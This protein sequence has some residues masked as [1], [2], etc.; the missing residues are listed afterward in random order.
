MGF[1]TKDAFNIAIELVGGSVMLIQTFCKSHHIGCVPMMNCFGTA[2]VCMK[3]L[4]CLH[5][6]LTCSSRLT[7][8]CAL[9]SSSSSV[10][11][12]SSDGDDDSLSLLSELDGLCALS[13][14]TLF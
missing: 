5:A 11:E 13:F 3:G 9:S 2:N 6:S 14:F 8:L 7:S 4:K 10:P 12:E 1:A